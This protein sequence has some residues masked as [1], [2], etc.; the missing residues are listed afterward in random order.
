[1]PKKELSDSH[2]ATSPAL[3]VSILGDCPQGKRWGSM[4]LVGVVDIH[5]NY[6]SI[7]RVPVANCRSGV[8]LDTSLIIHPSMGTC[9]NPDQKIGCKV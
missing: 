7:I 9:A 5:T 3:T 1:M 6:E 8:K 2:K 4:A